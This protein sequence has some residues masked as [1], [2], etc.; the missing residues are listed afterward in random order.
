MRHACHV[1]YSNSFDGGLGG[2]G[3]GGGVGVGMMDRPDALVLFLVSSH[4]PPTTPE[5]GKTNGAPHS[6]LCRSLPSAYHVFC[7]PRDKTSLL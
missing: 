7:N 6:P 2:T 4:L 3:G 5:R 1:I